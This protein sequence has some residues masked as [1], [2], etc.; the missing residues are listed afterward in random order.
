EDWN[1]CGA[2]AVSSNAVGSEMNESTPNAATQRESPPAKKTP[3][4]TRP[5]PARAPSIIVGLVMVAMAGLSIWYLVR[6]EPLLVQGEV[7]ATRFDL[8]ARVDGRVGEVPVTRGGSGAGRRSG[9]RE[10]C[11]ARRERRRQCR[12]GANRQPRNARQAR[13]GVGG[14]GRR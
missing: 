12:A 10:P 3:T 8:A 13:A 6:P 14:Q 4:D 2:N 5:R 1:F 11:A 7:D 9:G